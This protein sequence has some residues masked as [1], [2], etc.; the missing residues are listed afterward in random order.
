MLAQRSLAAF[1]DFGSR[2]GWE[3]DLKQVGYLFL[4]T[5]EDDVRDVRGRRGAAERPR[6]AQPDAHAGRGAGGCARR[7]TRAACWRAAFCPTDGHLTPE[8]VVAGY[9]FAA[10]GLGAHIETRCEVTGLRPGVVRT[11]HGDIAAP[12]VICAAGAWS[13]RRGP[14]WRACTCR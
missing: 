2:P 14:R 12:T 11:D 4:L 5:R 10:R 1:E 13:A 6:R 7:S 3:I 9:A 8:A